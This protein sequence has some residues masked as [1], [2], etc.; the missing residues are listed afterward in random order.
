ME[1]TSLV[2]ILGNF[3]FIY[4]YHWLEDLHHVSSIE[5]K[6]DLDTL[7]SYLQEANGT[8]G[9]HG[10]PAD[11]QLALRN[12]RSVNESGSYRLNKANLKDLIAATG[13]VTLLKLDSNRRFFSPCD[14]EI[15]WMTSKNNRAPLLYYNLSFV[16]HF[17]PICQ[18]KLEL[19]SGNAQLK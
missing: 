9:H 6:H 7:Y 4:H 11:C 10:H 3:S 14:L 15:W 12:V 17:K 1:K 19:Q 18:L 13:L 5:I 8:T 16:H 2:K